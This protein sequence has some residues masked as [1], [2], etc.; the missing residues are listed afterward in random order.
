M[1]VHTLLTGFLISFPRSRCGGLRQPAETGPRPAPQT[2]RL[3][4]EHKQA[5]GRVERGGQQHKATNS[6][7]TSLNSANSSSTGSARVHIG[8][9]RPNRNPRAKSEPPGQ[10]GPRFLQNWPNCDQL[11]SL[12]KQMWPKGTEESPVS[13]GDGLLSVPLLGFFSSSGVRQRKANKP[14]AL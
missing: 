6:R 8:T 1:V 11:P 10:V 5:E 2:G 9:P 14:A 4:S 7:C 13:S 12:D 3:T